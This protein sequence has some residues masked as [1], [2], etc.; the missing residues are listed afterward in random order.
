MEMFFVAVYTIEL[1]K[2]LAEG[3]HLPHEYSLLTSVLFGLLAIPVAYLGLKR[4]RRKGKRKDALLAL[5]LAVAMVAGWVWAGKYGPFG[6][7]RSSSTSEESKRIT[8][9]NAPQPPS[10]TADGVPKH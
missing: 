2:T 8:T 1:V 9:P 7:K 3:L 5:A 6:V 10:P 4:W